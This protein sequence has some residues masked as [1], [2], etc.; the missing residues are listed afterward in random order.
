MGEHRDA[1]H[2]FSVKHAVTACIF[3]N[4]RLRGVYNS[5]SG[6]LITSEREADDGRWVI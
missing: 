6:K 5:K 2:R 1:R 4:R 3:D